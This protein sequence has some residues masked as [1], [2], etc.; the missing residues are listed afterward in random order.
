MSIGIS[1]WT[2]AGSKDM[3]ANNSGPEG[4]ADGAKVNAKEVI[5]QDKGGSRGTPSHLEVSTE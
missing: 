4:N 1:A 3:G 2:S 5:V